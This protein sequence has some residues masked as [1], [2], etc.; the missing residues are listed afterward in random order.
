MANFSSGKRIPA[1]LP[2]GDVFFDASKKDF[3]IGIADGRLVPLASLLA[4][5]PI[6]GLDG[7]QGPKGDTGARGEKGDTGPQGPQGPQGERGA[8]FYA[9]NEELIQAF[10]TARAEMIAEKAKWIA[11]LELAFE[12]AGAI[13][14]PARALVL[15]HLETLRKRTL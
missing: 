5:P 13:V 9:G 4:G 7:P 6:Q 12:E 2:P 10:Q 8:V 3:Y 14:H 15:Q 1:S 11:A